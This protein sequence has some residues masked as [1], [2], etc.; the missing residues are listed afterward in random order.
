MLSQIKAPYFVAGLVLT[1]YPKFI[2]CTR[3]APIIKYMVGWTEEK[4]ATYC[5]TKN[6][7]YYRVGD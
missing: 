2:V 7:H 6:W 1:S 5:R 3:A 4:I